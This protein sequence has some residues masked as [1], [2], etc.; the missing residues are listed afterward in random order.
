MK[1]CLA[2]DT[3][4]AHQQWKCAVCGYEPAEQGGILRFAE[5][6]PAAHAGYKPEYFAKLVGLEEGHFWFRARN[7]LIQWALR[8]FFPQARSLF[9]IGCGTGFVLQGLRETF[10]ALQLQGSDLF[11]DGLAFARVRLPKVELYQMD[12]R[13]IPF[14]N[15]FDVVGAFD[16]IE[17][18]VDDLAVLEQVFHAAR[19]GGGVILTVPQHPF[20]WSAS[21]DHAQHQRRYR[22][23]E[24]YRKVESVGFR[25]EFVT[26]FVSLLL[27]LMLLSRMKR[28]R[29]N[30]F[31]PWE[32]FKISRSLN[33]FCE[34][35]LTWERALI[36]KGFSLPAGGSLLLIAKKVYPT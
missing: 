22:R 1:R 32:E 31:D 6:P 34:T 8:E 11:A 18:V 29:F 20:L 14:R 13:H 35:V 9:E 7:R 5:D 21:D 28:K 36:R 33:A 24:L 10:S 26:S 12:A 25:V 2:C 23:A 30:D 15:E 4:F 27:P 17:H 3:V 19:P 16:V